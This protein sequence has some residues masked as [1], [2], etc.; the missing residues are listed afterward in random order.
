VCTNLSQVGF[1]RER[2][3]VA[4]RSRARRCSSVRSSAPMDSICSGV[5]AGRWAQ[6]APP[7]PQPRAV[8]VGE[9]RSSNSSGTAASASSWCSSPP[10]GSDPALP[11]CVVSAHLLRRPR[12]CA[13]GAPRL[14]SPRPS[15]G[16]RTLVMCLFPRRAGDVS[17]GVSRVGWWG[18]VGVVGELFTGPPHPADLRKCTTEAG[19]ATRHSG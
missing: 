4:V 10:F 3:G 2:V 13:R 7:S 8:G 11:W 19:A 14:P 12:G 15:V 6:M 5:N 1:H 18:G 17:E 9:V 16:A